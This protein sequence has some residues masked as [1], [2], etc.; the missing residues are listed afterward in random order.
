[1]S[2]DLKRILYVEDVG[3]IATVAVMVLE[4]L[5]GFEVRH[6]LSGQEALDA[7]P[8]FAPQLVLLDVMMPGMDGPETLRRIREL[9]EG[10]DLPAIFMTAKAQVHEQDEY[11]AMGALGVIVKPFEPVS[12]SQTIRDMWHSRETAAA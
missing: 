12:L 3:S 8:G 7:L 2:D 4:D 11:I 6:F 5:G 1:M 9:P 10:R